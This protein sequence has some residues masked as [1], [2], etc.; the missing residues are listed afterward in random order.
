[1][2]AKAKP[3]KPDRTK[4]S[5]SMNRLLMVCP[6]PSKTAM[7]GFLAV[8]KKPLDVLPSPPMGTQ[9]SPPFQ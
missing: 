3:N 7:Y 6:L 4:L 2:T 8:K 1:M 5:E 9:P